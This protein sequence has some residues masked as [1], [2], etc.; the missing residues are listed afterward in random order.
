[1][2]QCQGTELLGHVD[3]TDRNLVFR[4]C[5]S[6]DGDVLSALRIGDCDWEHIDVD[7]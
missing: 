6:N 3:L 4:A 5:L 1:M 2:G 7:R